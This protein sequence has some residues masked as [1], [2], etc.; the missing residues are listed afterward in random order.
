MCDCLLHLGPDLEIVEPCPNLAA[1]LF[2]TSGASLQG[3]IFCDYIAPGVDQDRFIDAM[4]ES[5]SREDSTGVL[6]LC[7]RDARS[8]KVQAH[9]HYTFFH[10]QD[11]SPYHVIAITESGAW[12]NVA[13]PVEELGESAAMQS[14]RS[15]SSESS[16]E[17]SERELTLESVSGSDLGEIS[18]TFDDSPGLTVISCT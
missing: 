6:P 18:V 5:T 13:A 15:V 4:R 11:D 8:R 3:S 7:L 14:A 9:V 1:M 10:C 16:D 12:E 2:H 17:T